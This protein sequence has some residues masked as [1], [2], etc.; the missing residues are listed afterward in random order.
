MWGRH[1]PNPNLL[2]LSLL[3]PSLLS[4]NLLNLSL[5]NPSPLNLNLLNLSRRS[6]GLQSPLRLVDCALRIP[7][8]RA[9]PADCA[10]SLNRHHFDFSVSGLRG[11][12]IAEGDFLGTGACS[13][14]AALS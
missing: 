11:P 5:L 13:R 3:N 2:N 7:R 4:L 9:A 14:G 12:F 8:E 10:L 6:P 1:L